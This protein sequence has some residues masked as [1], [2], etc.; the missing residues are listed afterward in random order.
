MSGLVED[1]KMN[2]GKKFSPRQTLSTG[3]LL[4]VD[5]LTAVEPQSK[6]DEDSEG[7]SHDY[8]T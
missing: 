3:S 8:T 7:D 6:S 5:Y 2:L 1:L 4:T